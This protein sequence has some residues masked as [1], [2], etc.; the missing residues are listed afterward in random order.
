MITA[1]TA[2]EKAFSRSGVASVV[3][4][5]VP[6][7]GSAAP[8]VARL[9]IMILLMI[10]GLHTKVDTGQTLGGFAAASW[11]RDV[12]RATLGWR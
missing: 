6:F 12:V 4:M 1:N 10:H 11:S 7:D 5:L 9:L 3:T 8:Q 2:S